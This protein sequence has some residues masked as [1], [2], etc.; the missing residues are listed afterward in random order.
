MRKLLEHFHSCGLGGSS[1]S[2]SMEVD[3]AGG[4][5]LLALQNRFSREFTTLYL[6]MS[7]SARLQSNYAVARKYLQLTERAIDEVTLEISL[8][9]EQYSSFST[10][11]IF[12]EALTS[13]YCKSLTIILL[14]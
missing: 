14:C 12:L 7:D 9:K 3:G 11:S 5:D 8:S 1:T 13:Q 2:D 6:K 4:G 10:A